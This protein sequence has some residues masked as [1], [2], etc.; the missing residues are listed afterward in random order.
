MYLFFLTTD[1]IL[2]YP[3]VVLALK[4]LIEC[5][6]KDIFFGGG[7]GFIISYTKSPWLNV[8]FLFS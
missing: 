3:S 1:S 8:N 7:V 6:K 5:S 4:I 2:S